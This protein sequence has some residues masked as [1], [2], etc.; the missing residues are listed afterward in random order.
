[1]SLTDTTSI[2]ELPT[3]PSVGGNNISLKV[4]ESY[5]H[6]PVNISQPNNSSSLDQ[7]TIH[8]IVNGLQQ[9]SSTGATQLPSRDI[10]R[11]TDNLTQDPYIQPNYIA[12]EKNNDYIQQ[13]QE[14]EDIVYKY[15]KNKKN[16]D[17]LDD[18]YNEVQTPF[19]LAVLYFMF[20][21]PFFRKF[22]FNYIPMLFLK[23]GNLNLNG[24]IFTS[25]MFG[26]AYYILNKIMIQ[27]NAF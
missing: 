3:D 24:Y 5:N 26:L 20:Q 22:L 19:L 8:Q 17:S 21:L 23:D 16:S 7:T 2:L 27:F 12:P 9:A 18:V 4:T 14:N 25:G 11:N 1:M 6:N 10:P 13:M 15:N